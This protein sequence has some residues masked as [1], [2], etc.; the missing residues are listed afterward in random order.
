MWNQFHYPDQKC[1]SVC[2]CVC[3]IAGAFTFCRCL[4]TVTPQTQTGF[5]P[6]HWSVKGN[7]KTLLHFLI[8]FLLCFVLPW[9]LYDEQSKMNKLVLSWDAQVGKH[10]VTGE[11]QRT[12]TNDIVANDVPRPKPERWLAADVHKGWC[13]K[14]H[15]IGTWNIGSMNQGKLLIIKQQMECLNIAVLGVGELKWTGMEHLQ[16]WQL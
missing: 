7:G 8:L 13:C 14:T 9:K 3:V 2:F 15:T 16:S 4:V 11:E 5:R 6:T 12:S 1:T 10:S